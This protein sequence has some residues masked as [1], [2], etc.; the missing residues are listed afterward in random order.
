[1]LDENGAPID[2]G[3]SDFTM[4]EEGVITTADGRQYTLG[5]SYIEDYTDVEKVGDNLFSPY[6]NAPAGNIPDDVRY[7]LRQG[8]YERSNVDVADEMIKSLDANNVW[9]ANRQAL[10]IMNSI[11]QIACNDL[12][13]K[14]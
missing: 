11:N 5:L 12:M 3:T 9:N 1:M 13:K 6:Q 14:A 8:W 4:T 7:S 2:I 10:T